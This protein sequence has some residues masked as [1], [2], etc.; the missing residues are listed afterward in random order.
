MTDIEK[1]RLLTGDRAP[2]A[3][4][5]SDADVQAFLNAEVSVKGAAA[6]LLEAWSALYVA[7]PTSEGIGNYTY[8][9]KTVE[10]LLSLAKRLRDADASA[11]A[12]DYA[13]MDLMGGSESV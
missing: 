10:N 1:V 8:S 6:A 11:P 9:H 4:V 13:E 12:G 3:Q 2:A 7:N 5:F